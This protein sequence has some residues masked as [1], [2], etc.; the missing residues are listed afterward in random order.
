LNDAIDEAR[1]NVW[2]RQPDSF[3]EQATIDIDGHILETTGQCKEGMDMSYN[4]KWGYH[5]LIVSLAETGEVLTIKN[6]S[7]NRPSEEGAAPLIERY[8]GVCRRAGFRRIR[9]T[10]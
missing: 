1:L 6:R 5:P 9:G 3:F 8:I 2:A 10:R 4:G 7:E